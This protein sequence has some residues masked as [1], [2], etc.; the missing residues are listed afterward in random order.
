[1]PRPCLGRGS[2][3]L[4]SFA[5]AYLG[6]PAPPQG[7]PSRHESELAAPLLGQRRPW[8]GLGLRDCRG[9]EQAG[10]RRPPSGRQAPRR[11]RCNAT[12][13]LS[14]VRE[15]I[16][17]IFYTELSCV[18]GGWPFSFVPQVALRSYC[19]TQKTQHPSHQR[20]AAGGHKDRSNFLSTPDVDS[21]GQKV[22]TSRADK[23]CEGRGN[24][25]ENNS[26]RDATWRPPSPSLDKKIG[27]P[28]DSK[29]KAA[30]GR[31]GEEAGR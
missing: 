10:G 15:E 29:R 7:R 21:C 24:K 4:R 2:L 20:R 6:S 26:H 11:G 16:F 8:V 27:H 18:A 30:E 13:L 12:Q 9:W 5:L 14:I 28:A 31:R 17:P 25:T 3:G 1:M 23:R 19:A 22:W